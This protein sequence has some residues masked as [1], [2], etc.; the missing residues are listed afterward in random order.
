M[1]WS[2]KG[3]SYKEGIECIFVLLDFPKK[4]HLHP[5]QDSLGFFVKPNVWSH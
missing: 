5:I 3:H 2:N 1:S 4:Y